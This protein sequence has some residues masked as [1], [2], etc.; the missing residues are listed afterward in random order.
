[1][2][3]YYSHKSPDEMYADLE[4]VGFEIESKDY[5]DIGGEIFLWVT[6]SKF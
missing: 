2:T 3:I 4:A 5:R 1:M 6:L